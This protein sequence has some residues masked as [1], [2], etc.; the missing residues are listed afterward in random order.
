M[1]GLGSIGA[2]VGF[3]NLTFTYPDNALPDL[4]L[5]VE[6]GEVVVP[7]G[8]FV[9]VPITVTRLN[10]SAGA[11]TF[12]ASELPAGVTA[13]F[14]N[15]TLRLRAA[16]DAPRTPLD[17]ARDITI[18]A[19]PSSG[20]VAPTPRST[21]VPVRVSSNFELVGSGTA[22]LAPCGSAELALRVERDRAFT[23]TVASRPRASRRASP[24]RSNRR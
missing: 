2:R 14:V 23:G 10:G 20:D 16:A 1:D 7:Q 21:N 4:S 3:D 9:D 17:V 12:A 18:T 5:S 22:A 19:T 8:G 13:Q 11:F 6:P 15:S 24:P